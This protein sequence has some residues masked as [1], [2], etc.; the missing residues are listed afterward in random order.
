MRLQAFIFPFWYMSVFLKASLWNILKT[1]FIWAWL[2]KSYLN[3]CL[4]NLKTNKHE[5]DNGSLCCPNHHNI[6]HHCQPRVRRCCQPLLV[7]L[8]H[9]FHLVLLSTSFQYWIRTKLS[10]NRHI[11]TNSSMLTRLVTQ[12]I[13]AK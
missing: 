7:F 10:L 12:A 6:F 9:T 3:K 13:Q 1:S 2:V 4:T 8:G 11:M 5:L